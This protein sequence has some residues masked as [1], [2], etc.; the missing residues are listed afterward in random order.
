MIKKLLL[1]YALLASLLFSQ[2]LKVVHMEG[3]YDL[4]GD[5]LKEFATIES[6]SI[7]GKQISVIRYYEVDESGYQEVGWEFEAPDGVLGNSQPTS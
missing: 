4:D 3:T 2:D 1:A 7:G 6:G 5:G